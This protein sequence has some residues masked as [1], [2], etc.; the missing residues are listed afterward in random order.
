M[1]QLPKHN[2]D[3]HTNNSLHQATNIKALSS[4][5]VKKRSQRLR[6]IKIMYQSGGSYALE[7]SIS[8]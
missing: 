5:T 8:W 7:T 3:P 4:I 1:D 6:Q 2:Q